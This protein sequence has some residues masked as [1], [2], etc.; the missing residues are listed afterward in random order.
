M[1]FQGDEVYELLHIDLSRTPP[2]PEAGQ[3]MIPM[4]GRLRPP[5]L[6]SLSSDTEWGDRV[7][8]QHFRDR[9]SSRESAFK[10]T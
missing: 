7:D 1:L 8:L 10:L 6:Q 4:H 2:D 3:K 9:V 5:A